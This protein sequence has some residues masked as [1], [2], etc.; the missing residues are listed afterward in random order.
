[1]VLRPR[2]GNL[3]LVFRLFKSHSRQRLEKFK[4]LPEISLSRPEFLH[5]IFYYSLITRTILKIC[6][7]LRLFG[8]YNINFPDV[9]IGYPKN[10]KSQTICG[11]RI[12]FPS[13]YKPPIPIH[14]FL[15]G[16]ES[17]A[18]TNRCC[19]SQHRALSKQNDQRDGQSNTLR[20]FSPS[21]IRYW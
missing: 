9:K 13:I 15:K 12:C 5:H 11:A 18:K 3:R 14:I 1:M 20:N 16:C 2:E 21:R 10:K 8:H 19:N 7:I 17:V 6:M 4:N